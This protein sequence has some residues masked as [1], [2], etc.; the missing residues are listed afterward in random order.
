MQGEIT[1]RAPLVSVPTWMAWFL[2]HVGASA[3][4]SV[5]KQRAYFYTQ[6]S[7]VGVGGGEKQKP[8]KQL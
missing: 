1:P 8:E 4:G 2:K 3:V 5:E 6:R 7:E